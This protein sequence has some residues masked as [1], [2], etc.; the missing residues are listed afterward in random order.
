MSRGIALM[1]AVI[2]LGS[3][4]A[5]WWGARGSESPAAAGGT[6]VKATV[7][8]DSFV[9][10]LADAGQRSYLRVGIDLGIGRELGRD[11]PPPVALVRDT[12]LGVLAQAKVEELLTARGKENLKAEL[13]RTLNQRVPQLE[14][15]EIYFTEFLVQR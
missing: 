5:W 2:V 8:L 9:L 6:G 7:H 12:I 3:L 14:V 4:G 10:N 1:A 15:R 11:N 13:L